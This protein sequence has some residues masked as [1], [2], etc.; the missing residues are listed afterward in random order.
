MTEDLASASNPAPQVVQLRLSEGAA[1]LVPSAA[2][3]P[4]PRIDRVTP[5][6]ADHI[7]TQRIDPAASARPPSAPGP[8]RS[9]GDAEA[10][11]GRAGLALATGS[12][13]FVLGTVNVTVT[14]V[15]FPDIV[16]SFSGVSDAITGWIVSGYALAFASTIIVGGRLADRYGRLLVF[17]AGVLGL[18][19][20]SI[21][22]GFAPGIGVLLAARAVQGLCGALTVPSSLALVLPQF[23]AGRQASVIGI[24]AAAGMVA[25]GIAPG[26]AAVILEFS[27]WRGVY[28]AIAPIAAL[29]FLGSLRFL[30]ETAKRDLRTPLDLL[31]VI[32]GTAAVFLIVLATLQGRHWGWSS[33]WTL[34]C[35]GGGAALLP[36]FLLRSARHPEPLFDPRLF[37][38]RSFAVAN[39]AVALSMIG[40]FT[41]WFLWPL[42][43]TGVWGYSLLGVGLAFTPAPVVSGAV[44]ILSGRWADKHGFRGLMTLASVFATAG[45]LW[46]LFFLDENVRYWLALF[47]STMLFGLGLGVLASHLNSAALADIGAASIA[48]AN[49]VHQSLRY[50]LAAVG[51]AAAIAVL[52]GTHEVHLYNWMWLLLGALQ[53][54]CI[55]LMWFGYPRGPA[56]AR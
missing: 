37:R 9:S 29:A 49:G 46:L 18:L 40:A 14:N 47:P 4:P 43:L 26:L 25:S 13:A 36:L 8:H 11:R 32:M 52:G 44:A 23:P 21:V 35:F 10:P 51:V 2:G 1:R 56:S 3:A 33:A 12:L 38:I 45:M 34:A 19:V 42:F 39:L 41:S 48:T 28:L 53:A 17:R 16:R 27:S 50:G 55:P 5:E 30:Y 24:W 54:L 15:A 31:G 6:P 7:A 22:A 20:S